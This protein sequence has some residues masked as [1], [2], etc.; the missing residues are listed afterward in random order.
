MSEKNPKTPH[1]YGITQEEELRQK[2]FIRDVRP[3]YKQILDFFTSR[4]ISTFATVSLALLAIV[5][6]I[7]CD[8]FF[9]LGFFLLLLR[10]KAARYDRLP[11]R[12]P[13][14]APGLDYSRNL[15]GGDG[16]GPGEGYFMMGNERKWFGG[17]ELWLSPKDLCTHSLVFGTTGSGKTYTL[18]SMSYN[19]LASGSGLCYVDPKAEPSLAHN[20]FALA[21]FVGRDDDIRIKS[22]LTTGKGASITPKRLTNTNNPFAFGSAE[23][24]TNLLTSL[25]PKSEGD[26]ANFSQNAQTLVSGL[27]YALVELRDRGELQ[28]GIKAIREHMLPDNYIK[29]ATDTKYKLSDKAIDALKNFLQTVGYQFEAVGGK[30]PTKPSDS[31]Y[32]QYGFARSYFGLAL[33]S[34]V[35]AYGQVYAVEYGEIDYHDVLLNRRILVSLLP[36]LGVS[37]QELS[38]LGKIELSGLKTAAAIGLGDKIEGTVED[39]L[40]SL[41][42]AARSPHLMIVDEYAAITTPGFVLM[43][44]QARSLNFAAIIAT[45]DYSGLEKNDPKEAGQVLANTNVK[46]FLKTLDKKTFD[47][48]QDIAGETY[49]IKSDGYEIREENNALR[50]YKDG[51]R[52]KLDKIS[53]LDFRDFQ[54]QVEGQ[55][56]LFYDDVVIR[57]NSFTAVPKLRSQDQLRIRRMV[58]VPMPDPK[59]LSYK[60]GG[61]KELADHLRPHIADGTPIE[62][63]LDTQV[64]EQLEILA[65]AF[66]RPT[67]LS[68]NDHAI[69]V[70]IEM[71]DNANQNA[72]RNSR[73]Q[74]R[75]NSGSGGLN[76]RP[77]LEKTPEI[78]VKEVVQKKP[79]LREKPEARKTLGEI[80]SSQGEKIPTK[81]RMRTI[82]TV[83]EA[84]EETPPSQSSSNTFLDNVIKKEKELG[85]MPKLEA[86]RGGTDSKDDQVEEIQKTYSNESTTDI[87]RMRNLAKKNKERATSRK[88]KTG[89]GSDGNT[90][91]IKTSKFESLGIDFENSEIEELAMQSQESPPEVPEKGTDEITD[92]L[93]DFI[94]DLNT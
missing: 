51:Q 58:R 22:F 10:W 49:V 63:V 21:R 40:G 35:D 43:F 23:S 24:L 19:A 59:K 77:T 85:R 41:P 48:A 27:M 83:S 31:F 39:V 26:N 11:I 12:L 94:P 70:V 32:K 68:G 84:V 1:Q 60:K 65:S 37:E 9:V 71:I 80:E 66:N 42:A 57:G 18:I 69:A 15:P 20:I 82:E 45:Q 14:G 25:I 30:K 28:L 17:N 34:L 86:I 6:P 75:G 44:T 13:K 54:K 2:H 53:R 87:Q 81:P 47:I 79:N 4:D 67:T 8:V 29:L 78:Q 46:I 50:D 5:K 7:F 89:S 56:H 62:A 55:F 88:K 36:S 92:M 52:G 91:K 93:L 72:K 61:I 33:A 74:R 73:A 64:A 16:F 76:H 90:P 38:N 3:I